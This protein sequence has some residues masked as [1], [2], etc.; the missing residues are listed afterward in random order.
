MNSTCWVSVIPWSL[1]KM[2]STMFVRLRS[3]NAECRSFAKRSTSMSVSLTSFETG[4]ALWP[5]W[6]TDG[7]YATACSIMGSYTT[8]QI[9]SHRVSTGAFSQV[10]DLSRSWSDPIFPS[11]VPYP[12]M[13]VRSTVNTGRNRGPYPPRNKV[14][15]AYSISSFWRAW[16]IRSL[17]VGDLGV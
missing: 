3:A 10:E 1:T 14:C 12:R 5:A 11:R 4:P 16:P 17:Q 15:R 2:I 9:A 13:R 8:A 6:S 7:S